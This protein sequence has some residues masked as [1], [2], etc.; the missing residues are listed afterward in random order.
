MQSN[1]E[2]FNSAKALAKGPIMP[3][4]LMGNLRFWQAKNYQF[5]PL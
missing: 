5:G 3:V 1:F 2:L 4:I